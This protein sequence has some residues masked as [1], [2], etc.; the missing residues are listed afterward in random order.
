MFKLFDYNVL[1]VPFITVVILFFGKFFA[2]L[3]SCFQG[4]FQF[5]DLLFSHIFNTCKFSTVQFVTGSIETSGFVFDSN[6]F[7]FC[8]VFFPFWIP[9]NITTIVG[10]DPCNFSSSIGKFFVVSNKNDTT[11]KLFRS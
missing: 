3:E 4:F 10:N 8:C 9:F 6:N 5:L 7:L 2:V 1:D 11:L